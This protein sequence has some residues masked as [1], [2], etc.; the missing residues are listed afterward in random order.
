MRSVPMALLI[1]L[2]FILL[3][4]PQQDTG[5]RLVQS[6]TIMTNVELS[7]TV[8]KTFQLALYGDVPVDESFGVEYNYLSEEN[9]LYFCGAGT[10]TLCTGNGT[11]YTET[12]ILPRGSTLSFRFF[13]GTRS[14]QNFTE[15]SSG[16]EI[17]SNDVTS[18]AW[19][20]FDGESPVVG[21][22]GRPIQLPETGLF[23][24]AYERQISFIAIV[25][26]LLVISG[27]SLSR[28]TRRGSQG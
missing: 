23:H 10:N 21:D 2:L 6:D 27:Y 22:D 25:A 8:T 16:T 11:V 5:T 18:T 26:S 14:N 7:P 13:S 1:V 19:Y 24:L 28:H 17:L 20:S 15:I 3:M 12:T 4:Y 9:V